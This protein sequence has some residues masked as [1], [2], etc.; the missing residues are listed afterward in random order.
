MDFLSDKNSKRQFIT[1]YTAFII[2]GML[3]LSI[4]SLLPFIRDARG[5]DY[6]FAGLI[7]SLH[8]VGN[9]ISSFFAGALAA[10]IGRKRSILI[11]DIFCPIAYLLII[12][13]SNNLM[14]AAAFLL[15]GLARGANS[16]YCNTAINELAPGKAWI[17]NGLHA[18]FSVGAFL[19][20]I[21]LTLFTKN[22]GD[23]WIYAC[24]FMLVMGI[25]SF[26]LYLLSPGEESGGKGSAKAAGAEK[27]GDNGFGFFKERL[28]WLAI[29][30]LFFYLCA[31]QGVI[32][33][34]VTY[35][36]DTGYISKSLAQ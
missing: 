33:W 35:F 22:N 12:L 4:G 17:L 18:M 8:S 3:A 34:M 27:T 7:V 20:P 14:I 19:F 13:A 26:T 15:T 5:L 10:A 31:E 36:T 25:L 9:F 29:C 24:Y 11:F 32:G 28:F 1:C 6:A 21:L 23:G 2:N 30:T 16:N